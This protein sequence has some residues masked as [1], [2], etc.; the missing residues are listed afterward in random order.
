VRDTGAGIAPEKLARLFIPFNRLGQEGG[1]VPGTGIGLVVSRRLAELMDGVIEVEST[2]GVGSV[3]W[4]DLLSAIAP[5]MAAPDP[6]AGAVLNPEMSAHPARRTVLYVEDNPANLQLV[7]ELIARFPDLHLVTAVNGSLGIDRARV[8]LPQVI[9]MD[10]N[11]P[12]LSGIQAL[13]ILRE[14]F[15]TAHIPVIAVSAN[16]MPGDIEKGLAA[17][18]FRYLTKPI[19]NK[20]LMDTLR[21]AL[22]YAD[23]EWSTGPDALEC[24]S[25]P[26]VADFAASERAN[27]SPLVDHTALDAMAPAD[28]PART[29]RGN[30]LPPSTVPGAEPKP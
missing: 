4:C 1:S 12:G 23:R 11:L 24:V 30:E 26:S 17:G 20:E 7:E 16:A 22:E 9:L 25:P 21:E 18:F 14:G 10:I 3:F 2:V 19:K 13:K 15:V 6:E 5:P 29:Q 28:Q 8:L 27:R